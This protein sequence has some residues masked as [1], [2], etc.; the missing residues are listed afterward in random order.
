MDRSNTI[1]GYPACIKLKF[2]PRMVSSTTEHRM[3][4][5]PHLYTMPEPSWHKH[6]ASHRT[7]QDTTLRTAVGKTSPKRG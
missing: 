1:V 3:F 6:F 5:P 7:E 2:H 4:I